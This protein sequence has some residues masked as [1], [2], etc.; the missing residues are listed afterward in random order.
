MAQ[1]VGTSFFVQYNMLWS[2][3][4]K[5]EGTYNDI[6]NGLLSYSR[7]N[8]PLVTKSLSKR[9][10]YFILDGHHQIM[11]DLMNGVKSIWVNWDQYTKY[12]DAGIGNEFPVD[13]IRVVDF[14]KGVEA[15]PIEAPNSVSD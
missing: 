3:R 4:A 15:R 5:L 8:D 6:L 11:E 14:I 9:Q 10:A 1:K 12:I 2:T 13:A 7:S